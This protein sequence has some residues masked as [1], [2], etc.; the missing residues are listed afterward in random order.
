MEKFMVSL[1]SIFILF[2]V[3]QI[4]AYFMAPIVDKIMSPA[5][6]LAFFFVMIFIMPL[7][8][9]ELVLF[10]YKRFIVKKKN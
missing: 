10:L 9:T 1:M 4:T 8:S 3:F 7:L 6:N 5:F 2:S